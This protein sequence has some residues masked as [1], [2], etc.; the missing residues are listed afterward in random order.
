VTL[1]SQGHLEG[2][3]DAFREALRRA[4]DLAPAH[5]DLAY[6]LAS[7]GRSSEAQYHFEEA[8]GIDPNYWAAHLNYARLLAAMGRRQLALDHFRIAARSP[9]AALRREALGAL[10]APQW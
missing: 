7:Q 2:A 4:P 8:I 1:S 6:L 5:N 10:G 9:D 3:A